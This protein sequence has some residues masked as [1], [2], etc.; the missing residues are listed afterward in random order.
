MIESL[1]LLW[2]AALPLMGSPGPATLSLAGIGTAYGF[3][4]GLPYL[5]GIVAGTSGVVVLVASGLTAIVLAVPVL[6]DALALLSAG[7]ILYLAYRIATA[8]VLATRGD[9]AR[10]PQF[11][12]GFTLAIANPKA[13]AA[14]GAVVSGHEVVPLDPV[15]DAI[16]K[17]AGL[18]LLVF[19]V[20]PTWLG[21]GALF[22][23]VLSNPGW[24]RAANI[25]FAGL[26][27]A[28]LAMMALRR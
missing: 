17:G 2:L 5:V 26:L 7:Y 23:R 27:L 12:A 15:A 6:G 3:R 20:N 14:I 19:I 16:A 24:G 28:T 9:G 11:G 22:S 10:A 25:V 13:Y 4:G 1:L 8:P 21:L 18:I